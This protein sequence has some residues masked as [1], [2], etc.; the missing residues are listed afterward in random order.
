M[1]FFFHSFHSDFSYIKQ[2]WLYQFVKYDVFGNGNLGVN[3]FFVL[4][5]FLITYLL[6]IEK[7]KRGNVDFLKFYMRRALRIWPL[8]YFCVFFG[9]VIFPQL[10]LLF[11]QEPNETA[12]I[13]YY[14]SFLNN[15]DFI[16]NGLPDAS[17]LGVLWSIAVEEQFYLVWPIFIAFV[18]NK[19]LWIVF[20]LIILGTFIFR[21]I[22]N[23]PLI[24]EHHTFSCIGDMTIGAFAAWLMQFE[25]V[26]AW[27]ANLSRKWIYSLY[28]LFALIFFFRSEIFFN[29]E[30]LKV[31]ERSLIAVV[32]ALIILEQCYAKHSFYKFSK[33]KTISKL[34]LITYGL[35]CLHFIGIL[36]V[37]NLIK[38]FGFNTELWQVLL[39][40]S[41]LSLI[42]TII[43][44]KISFKYFE[45]PFLRLKNKFSR[46]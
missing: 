4:S 9:F 46:I 17:I 20:L 43:I 18:P 23:S 22:Y 36:V 16:E 38:K 6:L 24:H 25:A 15:F 12:N 19:K 31:I 3:V 1:V 37:T 39:I 11:G 45:K 13:W 28:F 8:F 30:W 44:S 27:I 10:K 40:D 21:S 2:E 41:S 35:Y 42:L 5:G 26:K 14:L 33:F 29:H 7:N 34:G 32:I